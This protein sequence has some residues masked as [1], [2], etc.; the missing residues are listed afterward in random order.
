MV[1]K[2]KPFTA[3]KQQSF[4][5][6]PGILKKTG[7]AL[8][9]VPEFAESQLERT[10]SSLDVVENEGASTPNEDQQKFKKLCD[11]VQNC[12]ALFQASLCELLAIKDEL[13]KH[14][15]PPSLLVKIVLVTG[16]LFRSSS[17][18]SVPITELVRMVK[19]Y[20]TPWET[21]SASLKKLHDDYENKQR[22]LNV[23]LQKLVLVGIQSERLAQE[24]KVLNWEKLFS[25]MMTSKAH[26][27]RWKFLIESFKEK[28][29]TGEVY[30]AGSS[31]DEEA[32]QEK[33]KNERELEYFRRRN[34]NRDTAAKKI[35]RESLGGASG[36]ILPTST[37]GNH[38]DQ[39]ENQDPF[40]DEDQGID[41]ELSTIQHRSPTP[42]QHG[43]PSSTPEKGTA[44]FQVDDKTDFQ[45]VQRP[46]IK[47]MGASSDEDSEEDQI[48]QGKGHSSVKF[49]DKPTKRK[50]KVVFADQPYGV[51]PMAASAKVFHYKDE[52]ELEESEEEAAQKPITPL[53]AVVKVD[54]ECWTHE[55]EY[56]K[57]LHL[58]I[59]KPVCKKAPTPFC[60]VA[61]HGQFLKTEVFEE[62]EEVLAVEETE[63]ISPAPG[64]KT[65]E[66]K[67]EKQTDKQRAAGKRNGMNASNKAIAGKSA[68]RGTNNRGLSPAPQPRPMSTNVGEDKKPG[69]FKELMFKLPDDS[70][71][72]LGERPADLAQEPL[73]FAVHPAVDRPV[74]AMAT[75]SYGD[76][77]ILDKVNQDLSSANDSLPV[78]QFALASV[79]SHRDMPFNAK[80]GQISLCCFLSKVERLAKD[81]K[82]TET[83]PFDDLVD[84]TIEARR[85]EEID[86]QPKEEIQE[87][88][89]P[90]Y[91]EGD[92][93]A[94][95]EQHAEELLLLQEEYQKRLNELAQ[96][97]AWYPSELETPHDVVDAATSPMTVRSLSLMRSPTPEQG[98]TPKPPKEA[99]PSPPR[100]PRA[101]IPNLPEWGKD[102]PDDFLLRLHLFNE[103]SSKYR[104]ELGE[105]TR[106]VVQER[107]EL[108]MAVQNRLARSDDCDA[109]GD[110][111]VCLPAVFMPTRSGHV[112]S[113]KAHSYFHPPGSSEGRLTQPPS[114]FRLP[115]VTPESQVSVLNLFEI[116]KRYRPAER[117]WLTEDETRPHTIA[118]P[119]NSIITSPPPPSCEVW[120]P[121]PFHG[122]ASTR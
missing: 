53:P 2:T 82:S 54:K 28:V 61:F 99:R 75:I 7:T 69:V 56:D 43:K 72:K 22:Q 34:M 66:T 1:E 24:R 15:L 122:R 111:D 63:K 16:K 107:Y 68:S 110:T 103:T 91:T 46:R 86:L 117:T 113:P 108:Q 60:S 104:Q 48:L 77:K 95:K 98:K 55:P 30:V 42:E 109:L 20:S 3:E 19:L 49:A 27:Y 10:D 87:T 79:V 81:T 50:P 29:K 80:C 11:G 67:K 88:P 57:Y 5:K 31:T 58:R 35:I 90:M 17:D 38:L 9:S 65:S 96:G 64:T 13:L 102:L 6:R 85:Q 41:A 39:D 12:L 26:G 47:F 100:K 92:V 32:E 112:Y 40:S 119:E 18:L 93:R 59:Y 52:D 36:D 45:E 101:R 51:R 106:K 118:N 89:E 84:A 70:G 114:I 97:V 116:S 33:Q 94:L 74:I 44:R 78:Q 83:I 121:P 23:A 105:K 4:A 21:K 115:S 76:L 8:E 62:E 73:R 14:A 25:K 37:A 71:L 120:S